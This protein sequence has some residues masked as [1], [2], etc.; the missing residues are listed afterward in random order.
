MTPLKRT[1]L[2]DGRAW[3]AAPVRHA[4]FVPF[5]DLVP[6]RVWRAFN[7]EVPVRTGAYGVI[8][9]ADGCAA[10]VD[11]VDLYSSA[12]LLRTCLIV[13]P[14]RAARSGT[15][16]FSWTRDIAEG[17]HAALAVMTLVEVDGQPFSETDGTLHHG[18]A[19]SSSSGRSHASWWLPCVPAGELAVSVRASSVDLAGTIKFDTSSWPSKT[20]RVLSL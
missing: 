15:Q 17:D 6:D 3:K 18:A 5:D 10:W 13:T 14:E 8:A 1:D 7:S 16:S 12:L 20:A 19:G 11:A 9:L 2:F 4:G